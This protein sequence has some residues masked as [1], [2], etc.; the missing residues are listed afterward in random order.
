MTKTVQAVRGMNDILP[1][2]IHV[3]QRFE[4]TVR[5]WLR[6]YG[7]S[8]I[9]MPIVEHTELFVRSIGD[10]TDIVEKEMYTFI[11]ALSAESLTLR[12]EGTASCV[13]AEYFSWT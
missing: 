3:W 8:E 5:A 4:D 2:E 1:D 9:R 13:R 6:A 12:P 10:A 7:Y 11:D